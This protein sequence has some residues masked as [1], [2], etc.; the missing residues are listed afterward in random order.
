VALAPA[1]GDAMSE[2]R[3]VHLIRH[4]QSDF[5]ASDFRESPR[6]RQWDPPLSPI[7]REQAK[8]LTARLVLL[9]RIAAVYCSPFRRARETIAPFAERTDTEV[10]YEED[11]GEAFAGAWEAA[12]FEELLAGD[13]EMLQRFRDQE[14]MWSLAPGAESIHDLRARV[15]AVIERSL[16]KNAEGDVVLVAHGGVINAYVGPLLGIQQ[17]MFYL[18]ENTSLNTVIADGAQRR[19]RF[20]NDVRHLTE[21][22]LF[23]G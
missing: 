1:P 19:V 20:L 5:E 9:R 23:R 10:R 2:P 7:G 13:E 14:P 15:R 18:P 12:S 3:V 17:E 16:A 21:P 11:L 6:G 8:L 22:H 4:G